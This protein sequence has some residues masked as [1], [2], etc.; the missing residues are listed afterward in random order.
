MGLGDPFLI[1]SSGRH[2][3]LGGK[4]SRINQWMAYI[5][6]EVR[7]ACHAKGWGHQIRRKW[8][9]REKPVW[10]SPV[11]DYQWK[12]IPGADG[13][14]PEAPP[15]NFDEGVYYVLSFDSSHSKFILQH[16][17]AHCGVLGRH[18]DWST[19]T[20]IQ[21]NP[22]PPPGWLCDHLLDLTTRLGPN[23]F[24]ST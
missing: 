6:R 9:V 14:L 4:H 19:Y 13:E 7:A 15:V 3:E 12:M 2:E 16:D 5:D 1:S 22:P 23:S 21:P 20:E 24:S 8:S 11:E 10:E 17:T 18:W